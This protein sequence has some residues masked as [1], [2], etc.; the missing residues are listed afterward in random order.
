M[1]GLGEIYR[2]VDMPACFPDF[3]GFPLGIVFN[4]EIVYAV[5]SEDEEIVAT[6]SD[7]FCL[8]ERYGGLS[9]D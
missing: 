5:G 6:D 8:I 1:I 4:R 7:A 3:E 2:D 9:A